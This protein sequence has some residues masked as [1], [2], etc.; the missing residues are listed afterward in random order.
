M[1]AP[2]LEH[3]LPKGIVAL[4]RGVPRH[5][6]AHCLPRDPA[7]PNQQCEAIWKQHVTLW[8]LTSPATPAILRGVGC[9]VG[10]S[11]L[12]GGLGQGERLQTPHDV[13]SAVMKL[14]YHTRITEQCSALE[15]VPNVANLS[16]SNTKEN[17]YGN[18][19][20][21]NDINRSV[22]VDACE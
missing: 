3:S 12:F 18:P 10:W 8:R 19:N 13:H 22:D 4:T 6:R 14:V 7:A 9:A 15:L 1:L 2:Q 17:D 20:P 5:G 11:T 16:C 21:P